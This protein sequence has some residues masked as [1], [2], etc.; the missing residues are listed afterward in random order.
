MQLERNL[1]SSLSLYA[2]NYEQT[3]PDIELNGTDGYQ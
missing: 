1:A 2:W 3:N